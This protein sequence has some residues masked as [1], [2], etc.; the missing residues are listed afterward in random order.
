M[1]D[2]VTYNSLIE[3]ELNAKLQ[4]TRKELEAIKKVL[5]ELKAF[6]PIKP[7]KDNSGAE[8]KKLNDEIGKTKKTVTELDRATKNLTKAQKAEAVTLAELKIQ[9]AEVDKKNKEA[10][11]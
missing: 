11:K 5:V 10:A 6:K 1:E 8:A 4:A 2:K 7:I 9:K 3:A